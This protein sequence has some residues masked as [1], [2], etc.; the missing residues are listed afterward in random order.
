MNVSLN[1]CTL[2]PYKTVMHFNYFAVFIAFIYFKAS[3]VVLQVF[4]GDIKRVT[5]EVVIQ[6]P[7]RSAV[8]GCYWTLYQLIVDAPTEHLNLFKPNP[9]LDLNSLSLVVEGNLCC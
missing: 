1:A 4:K 2:Y 3:F 5:R 8:I 7:S 6:M 9:S